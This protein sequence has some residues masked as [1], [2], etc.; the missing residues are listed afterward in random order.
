MVI[1]T[2]DTSTNKTGVCYSARIDVDIILPSMLEYEVYVQ[3]EAE[4]ST[5]YL[6]SLSS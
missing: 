2:V 3:Y 5:K 6:E 4:L 1:L